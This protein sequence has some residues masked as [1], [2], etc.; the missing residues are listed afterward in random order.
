M[1][2]HFVHNGLLLGCLFHP[3]Y[4][5][6]HLCS[7]DVVAKGTFPV[8][9]HYPSIPGTNH[10]NGSK[11]STIPFEVALGAS[12]L[13]PPDV[14]PCIQPEG[15]EEQ[16]SS[17]LRSVERLLGVQIKVTL[18][19]ISEFLRSQRFMK[20]SQEGNLQLCELWL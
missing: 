10:I 13:R 16:H 11:E 6:Q 7:V 9:V 5:S 8:F 18:E 4:S 3:L 2:V 19:K 15:S 17:L 1:F 14:H 12:L 20:H